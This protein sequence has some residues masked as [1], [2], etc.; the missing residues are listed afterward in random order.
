M[1]QKIRR[2]AK[3]FQQRSVK[4][5]YQTIHSALER[6]VK[7]RVILLNP[8][9]H[10]ELP[11]QEKKEMRPFTKEELSLFFKASK[12]DRHFVIFFLAVSTGMRRGENL[13]LTWDNINFEKGTIDI[14]KQLVRSSEQKRL[15]LKYLKTKTSIRTVKVTAEVME[16]LKNHKK[17]QNK[18][19]LMLGPH[20]NQD[21]DL[22]FATDNGTFLEPN[23]MVSRHFKEVIKKHNKKI[24]EKAKKE[25]LS[26]EDIKH[27]KLP[28]IRFHDLRHTYA[29][30][31]LEA[32]IDLATISKNLGHSSYAITADTYSHMTDT[33]KSDAAEVICGVVTGCLKKNSL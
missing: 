25:G 3:V 27:E 17:E 13:G 9:K 33:I 4:Y 5:I 11:K 20:Y 7:N 19:K 22:V 18:K 8:A 14:K 16:L 28:L 29:T 23:N 32:G 21:C 26:M 30:L 6:A 15:I 1:N 31:S 12:E 2:P 24:K 10:V